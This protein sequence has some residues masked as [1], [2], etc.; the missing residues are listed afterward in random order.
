LD[1]VTKKF[2]EQSSFVTLALRKRPPQKPLLSNKRW[3]STEV[4][5]RIPRRRDVDIIAQSNGRKGLIR[6]M[7]QLDRASEIPTMLLYYL[8]YLDFDWLSESLEPPRKRIIRR[9]VDDESEDEPIAYERYLLSAENVLEK[10]VARHD[11]KFERLTKEVKKGEDLQKKSRGIFDLFLFLNKIVI[12]FITKK[13]VGIDELPH[14]VQRMELLAGTDERF[15]YRKQGFGYLDRIRELTGKRDFSKV[16]R[17]LGVLPH[18]MVL[19]KIIGNLGRKYLPKDEYLCLLGRLSAAVENACIMN[20]KK[21]KVSSVSRERLM[22]VAEEYDEFE[23]FS[24]P[25]KGLSKFASAMMKR[26]TRSSLGKCNNCGVK[27]FFQI[28]SDEY[29]CPKCAKKKYRRMKTRLALR[30]CVA[31]KCGFTKWML[32]SER[33]GLIFCEKDGMLMASTGGKFYIPHYI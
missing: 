9:S 12:W 19:S 33:P 26:E 20:E 16:Y 4:M 14:I 25:Y 3:I 21:R 6:L 18:F 31:S 2:C 10:I 15:W 7:N 28:S 13:H 22:K 27:T 23:E 1:D 30:R 32:V 17:Q 29:L 5:E 8:Q 24:L 11:K